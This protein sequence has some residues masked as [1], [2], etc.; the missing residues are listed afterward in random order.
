MTA[1]DGSSLEA[2]TPDTGDMPQTA[3]FVF[4]GATV[5]GNGAGSRSASGDAAAGLP[6]AMQARLAGLA[7]RRGTSV[8]ALLAAAR[9]LLGDGDG[10]GNPVGHDG[11]GATLW[12]A[13]T[14]LAVAGE[15]G[16][17]QLLARHD[18]ERLESRIDSL[19]YRGKTLTQALARL[20]FQPL[21]GGIREVRDAAQLFGFANEWCFDEDRVTRRFRELA[22]VY[23]PDTGV[24]A[25]RERMG[26][27]VEARNL[28]VRHVRTAYAAG[29]WTR[30]RR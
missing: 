17:L 2:L 28:L 20:S 8:A 30:R 15:G 6:V 11:A 29:K 7:A 27:L 21:E 16:A 22:L 5:T 24:V 1:P 3:L 18:V 13:E 19:E 23:H 25:D 26:Q 12:A 10:D 14:A 9:L 4:P